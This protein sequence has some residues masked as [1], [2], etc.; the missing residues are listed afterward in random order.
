M[1]KSRF[2]VLIL[3]FMLLAFIIT[4]FSLYLI[5]DPEF[6]V[7]NAET[8]KGLPGQFIQLSDGITHYEV[9]NPDSAKTIILVHGYS[10]PY[11]I[12]NGMF[13]YLAKQGFHVIRYDAFGRGYSDRP[14]KLYD[15]MLF[16]K[17]LYELISALHIK[18]PVSLAG[19]SFGGAV[20]GDFVVHYPDLVDKI[21]LI[22]PVYQ[23]KH[24]NA[25]KTFADIHIAIQSEDIAEGQLSDFKY[26]ANFPNWVEQYRDQ[27]KYKGFRNAYISTRLDYD[28]PSIIENYKKLDLL[29]KKVLLIWGKDDQTVPFRFSDSLR[30]LLKVKFLPVADAGHLPYLEQPEKVNPEVLSFLK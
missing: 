3:V 17:Q 26:P 6:K 8:R 9:A 1:K 7:L 12:W 19:V 2:I 13:E 4:V 29:H 15:T 20:V 16:R 18:N 30:T 10:V 22:D 5:N 14:E 11:F 28:G 21:I 27:M 23:F 25:Q 24:L